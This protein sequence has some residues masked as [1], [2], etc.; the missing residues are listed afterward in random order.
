MNAARI[1]GRSRTT[2]AIPPDAPAELVEMAVRWMAACHAHRRSC[3]AFGKVQSSVI[4]TP[5]GRELHLIEETT[6]RPGSRIPCALKAALDWF[7]QQS[8]RRKAE[9]MS[10]EIRLETTDKAGKPTFAR[11]IEITI[12]GG[13]G[14]DVPRAG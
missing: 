3:G 14:V 2:P 6:F 5:T 7:R 9:C 4:D 8:E 1:T 12:I 11:V 10:G 13:A